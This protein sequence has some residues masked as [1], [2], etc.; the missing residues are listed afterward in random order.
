[1]ADFLWGLGRLSF[2]LRSLL[3]LGGDISRDPLYYS[4]DLIWGDF[5][6]FLKCDTWKIRKSAKTERSS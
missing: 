6:A 3:K 2:V 1:M 5:Y 4:R